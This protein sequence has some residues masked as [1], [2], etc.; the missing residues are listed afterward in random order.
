MNAVETLE[1]LREL[2]RSGA[3]HF[4]SSEFEVQFTSVSSEQLPLNSTVHVPA[5]TPTLSDAPVANEEATEKLKGLI[6]TLRMDD[7][8]LLDTIFPAGAGG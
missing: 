5:P 4:K 6:N 3:V 2:K 7:S 8:K 1:I